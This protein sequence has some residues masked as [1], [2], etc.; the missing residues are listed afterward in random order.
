MT[1]QVGAVVGL[2]DDPVEPAGACAVEDDDL[3]AA[4]VGVLRVG[5]GVAVEP[6]VGA[7]Q[8]DE[9]VRLGGDDEALVGQARRRAPARCPAARAAGGPG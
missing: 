9:P 4:R 6:D 7:G 1:G 3:P 2:A 5:G 8:L